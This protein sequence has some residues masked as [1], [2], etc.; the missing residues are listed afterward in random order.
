MLNDKTEKKYQLKRKTI[1]NRV[2][3]VNPQIH[4]MDYE[5]EITI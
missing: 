3:W 4:H 5:T 2:K 1:K